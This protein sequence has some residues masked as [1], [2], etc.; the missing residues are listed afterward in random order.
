M[1][2]RRVEIRMLCADVVD[3]LWKDENGRVRRSQANLE[4]IS[5]SGA[6]LEFEHPVPVLATVRIRHPRG[7]LTGKV[8]YCVLRET[9]YLVGV[10]FDEGCRRLE[11]GFRPRNLFDPR[12][13]R[14][15]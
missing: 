7:E 6:G 8:K 15:Q 13:L 4:D 14:F 10:E 3:I 11:A 9:G 5:S 1:L 2:D 12:K